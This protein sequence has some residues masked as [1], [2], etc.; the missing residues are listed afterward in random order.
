MQSQIDYYPRV[1]L[2]FPSNFGIIV[3]GQLLTKI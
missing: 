2:K 1:L 3:Q